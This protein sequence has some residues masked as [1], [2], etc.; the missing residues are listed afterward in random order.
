MN[1]RLVIDQLVVEGLELPPHERIALRKAVHDS[2]A[3]TLLDRAAARVLPQERRAR[4]ETIHLAMA[5]PAAGTS[6][7]EA[8]GASI[9]SHVW[10][11]PTTRSSNQRGQ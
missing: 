3:A 9:T 2:L 1:I 5:G 8:I 7:G 6:W 4:R 10:A 11:S